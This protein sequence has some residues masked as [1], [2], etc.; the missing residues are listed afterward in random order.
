[1]EVASSPLFSVAVASFL[2]PEEVVSS[3]GSLKAVVSF[4]EEEEVAVFGLQLSL[5]LV[6]LSS[7]VEEEMGASK[8]VVD[9]LK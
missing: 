9:V 8:Q 5:I 2:R 6:A 7:L 4:S 1:V 3:P